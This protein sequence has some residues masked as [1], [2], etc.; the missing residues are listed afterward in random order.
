MDKRALRIAYD[1]E[2]MPNAGRQHTLQRMWLNRRVGAY[3][4]MVR[5]LAR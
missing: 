4:A 1:G 2:R 5:I 3:L